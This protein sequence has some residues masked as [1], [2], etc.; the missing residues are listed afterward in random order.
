M[1]SPFDALAKTVAATTAATTDK[2]PAPITTLF[3]D[4]GGVVLTN[5]WDRLA[6]QR[7]AEYFKLDREEM[8]ERHN[9][10]FD[11]YESGKL[12]LDEYLT[13]VVFYE[14]RAF[15]KDDFRAFMFDQSR[16]HP[17]MIDLF[18]E[19]K[20]RYHLR[21]AA[22]SNEG[23]ELTAYRI[24]TFNLKAF[25]DFFIM[26]CYVHYRKPDVDIFEIALSTAQVRPQEVIY[27]DDRSLF[28]EVASSLGL[29]GIHHVDYETTRRELAALG[30][31]L[32]KI[33]HVAT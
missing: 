9:L 8:D 13:R 16:P 19:L 23:H 25:V 26:S 3:L 21:I 10:T 28:V 11:T 33:N 29:R 32:W 1:S 14:P 15:S 2:S 31:N 6:R 17:E 20:K 24:E 7:A 27:V 5:G 30:L 4:I 12:S 18:C 22:V